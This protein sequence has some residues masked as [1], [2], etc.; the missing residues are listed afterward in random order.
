MAD[1]QPLRGIRYAKEAVEDLGQVVTPPFDVISPEEQARYYARHPHN[2]IRLELGL[3]Q[4]SDTMLDNRYSRAAAAFA[5]WRNDGILSQEVAPCYYLYQ[6]VF[7]YGEQTFTRTSLLARVRLEPWSVKV[8]LPHELTMSKPKADRLRLMQACASNFSP[9]MSMYEDPQGRIRRLLATYAEKPEVEFEDELGERHRL[10]PIMDKAVIAHIQDFF[11]E[12]QL[13]IADGHHRYETALA[14]REQMRVQR[15]GLQPDDAVNFVMM[16]LIDLDDPGLLEL[17]THRVLFNLGDEAL[18]RL[19]DERLGQYFIVELSAKAATSGEMV[20]RLARVG[21][22]QA[23]FVV[24]T[25]EENWLLRPNAVARERMRQ[26]GHAEAWNE[27]DVSVAHTLLLKDVLGISEEDVTA[28]RNIRYIRDAAEAVQA[29]KGREYQMALLLNATPV[30]QICEVARADELMP[31]K[32]T[33][34]YP[35]LITGLVIN[36]LW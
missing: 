13:F 12:R 30:R 31:Q 18:S 17:P 27:L 15:G 16:A 33:Y 25:A 22:E 11:A 1:V 10:Q 7:R 9:L 35:K 19:S 28:G 4:E 20:E 2:M 36:P 24:C 14:Y 29:V 5:E 34:F 3:G 6:Q 21:A 23:A 26:S 32:A 8:V